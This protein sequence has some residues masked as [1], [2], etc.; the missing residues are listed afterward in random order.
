MRKYLNETSVPLSMAVFLAVDHYDHDDDPHTISATSLLK[1]IRQIVLGARVPQEQ[2]AQDIS[3]LVPSRMGTAIHDGF[4]RAWLHHYAR[5]MTDLGYPKKVIEKVRINPKPD[6]LFDGCIPVYLE[7]RAYREINGFRV[8]GKF[9]FV[10]DGRVEDVKTTSVNSWIMGTKDDDYILQG[11][12]YRW[13]NPEIITQDTMAIQFMFTDWSG[14]QAR[15]GGNYPANRTMQKVFTLMSVDETDRWVHN[16]LE[17]IK[18]Y[19]DAPEADIPFCTDAELWRRD[20]VWKYYKNPDK[21]SRSTKN[22]DN[23]H[24]AYMRLAQDGNVGIVIE[25]PGQAVACRYCPAFPVC[26]QA[27]SLLASGDLT[28]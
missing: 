8:S 21:T 19:W 3:G 1:P 4:E 17:L 5:A 22:F 23:R 7:Q 16:R 20:P 13:L 28:L 27:A 12:I 11:S 24:D 2:T 10:G 6:E 15:Q 18:R 26:S 14:M 9:D 25:Q